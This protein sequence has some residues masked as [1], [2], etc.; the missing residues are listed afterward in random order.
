MKGLLLEVRQLRDSVVT[1]TSCGELLQSSEQRILD[2][3][4]LDGLQKWIGM[5]VR[6]L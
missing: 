1:R 3:D 4:G 2:R 5:S 6:G